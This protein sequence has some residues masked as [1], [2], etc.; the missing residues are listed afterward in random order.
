MTIL[1][2][3]VYLCN[4]CWSFSFL[5]FQNGKASP[6]FE[7]PVGPIPSSEDDEPGI[8]FEAAPRGV[9]GRYPSFDNNDGDNQPRWVFSHSRLTTANYYGY[10]AYPLPRCENTWVKRKQPTRVD[11]NSNCQAP[12]RRKR[13]WLS[14]IGWHIWIWCFDSLGESKYS[15]HWPKPVQTS[16]RTRAWWSSTSSVSGHGAKICARAQNVQKLCSD[17]WTGP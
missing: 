14:R 7:H 2:Y 1:W 13:F 17:V 9:L 16:A 3:P 4:G 8:T 11:D 6:T 12:F 15:G 10:P 5:F